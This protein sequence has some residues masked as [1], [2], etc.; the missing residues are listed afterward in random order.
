MDLHPHDGRER[1][2]RHTDTDPGEGIAL[3]TK[4]LQLPAPPRTEGLRYNLSFYSGGS[5][6][7]DKL[8]ISLPLAPTVAE[9]IVSN[10]EAKTPEEAVGDMEW[11]NEF[12]WLIAD[13]DGYNSLP[14][15]E[16]TAR[17]VSQSRMEFQ[18]DCRPSDPHWF[19]QGSGVNSWTALWQCG[20]T[21]S[22]LAYD[23]G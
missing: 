23:Q 19:A 3:V 5:G 17:F 20:G 11:K 22:F 2:Y 6:V 13:E 16:E 7:V 1:R 12:L 9:R 10:L 15:R 18:P 14:L 21:L 8:A 4:L